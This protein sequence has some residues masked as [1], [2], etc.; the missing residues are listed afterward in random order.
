MSKPELK[1]VDEPE[2]EAGIPKPKKF[3][4]DKFTSKRASAIAGVETQL[5]GLP[6]N[7]ISHA[8]DFVRLHPDEEQ[9]WTRELCFVSVP[10]KGQ[11]H[12][13]LHL[14][15]EELAVEYL[16]SAR[17]L[18]FKLAL[19]SKPFDIF[20]L[21]ETPTRNEDNSWNASA[22]VAAEQAKTKWVEVTSRREEGV[23]SY[24]IGAARDQD[25]FPAPKWPQQPLI[26]LLEKTF[27]GRIIEQAD[28]PALLRLIGARQV[29]S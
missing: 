4:L 29:L 6:H 2:K 9:Y 10:I 12:D 19:A 26:D 13:T 8:K 24:K 28:H 27:A 1:A 5:T 25:A 22:L 11:K 18:R 16:P 23:D 21:C 7:K 17:I 3:S 20:F 15:D 14:I